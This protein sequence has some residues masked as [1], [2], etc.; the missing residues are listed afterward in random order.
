MMF[1]AGGHYAEN[2]NHV[3]GQSHPGLDP[4]RHF[5]L[6]L[7]WFQCYCPRKFLNHSVWEYNEFRIHRTS[8]G[9]CIVCTHQ[10]LWIL[11]W[12]VF[13]AIRSGKDEKYQQESHPGHSI[14]KD[15]E[16]LPTSESISFDR[17]NEKTFCR[18]KNDMVSRDG[19]MVGALYAESCP[20][21]QKTKRIL[22]LNWP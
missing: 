1:L 22:K 9:F 17:N 11:Q 8:L 20:I 6:K 15:Q 13:Q 3:V 12:W 16:L 2:Q 7:V 18:C 21:E 5:W 4:V 10:V 14:V 19:L